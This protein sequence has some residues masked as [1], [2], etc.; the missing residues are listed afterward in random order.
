M[1]RRALLASGIALLSGCIA[2]PATDD[3]STDTPTPTESSPATETSTPTE[4]P[5]ADDFESAIDDGIPCPSPD[6][7]SWY[8]GGDETVCSHALDGDEEI[9]LVPD[10]ERV[11][12]GET[13]SIAMRAA[14]D[15]GT[16]GPFFWDVLVYDRETGW[17]SVD[18]REEIEEL[19]TDLG[20]GGSFEWTVHVGVT[21][22]E[23]GEAPYGRRDA[24][25]TA[26]FR[27]GLYAFVV[28]APSGAPSD[29]YAA[30][31][32]VEAGDDP[33]MPADAGPDND[34]SLFADEPCPDG[35][36]CF[37]AADSDARVF[38]EPEREV[39]E[40]GGELG[41]TVRNWTGDEV[42]FGPYHWDVK[43]RTGDGWESVDERDGILDL[44]S[45]LRYG[46]S[47][48]IEGKATES[49]DDH[50]DDLTG[51]VAFEPGTHRFELELYRGDR[52]R[53]EHWAAYFRVAED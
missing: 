8:I 1:H 5:P 50:A 14:I 18:E 47:W 40:L 27:P 10:R 28:D 32:E 19:G 46:G 39:V 22:D 51:G 4:I 41:F 25:S 15:A 43:R 30:L 17:E 23:R 33:P 48:T 38:L 16:L 34:D 6:D 29:A 3:S 9:A 44:G 2:S 20:A 42:S 26:V 37:H 11:A 52:D 53:T 24:G 49:T 13:I 36:R 31:F 21:A 12:L 7:A 45:L 35:L